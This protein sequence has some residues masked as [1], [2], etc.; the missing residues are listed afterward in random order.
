MWSSQVRLKMASSDD[1]PTDVIT[2][3]SEIEITAFADKPP[4]SLLDKPVEEQLKWQT[5][6]I[7]GKLGL[8]NT[9]E[10]REWIKEVSSEVF[11]LPLTRMFRSFSNGTTIEQLI[12]D[13]LKKKVRITRE[14]D[15]TLAK[16][17]FYVNFQL[18]RNN[19]PAL[20]V[21]SPEG[22]L[23]LMEFYKNGRL[24]AEGQPAQ[25]LFRANDGSKI[26]ES[27][28]RHGVVSNPNGPAMVMFD[29]NNSISVQMWYEN[30]LPVRT[31]RFRN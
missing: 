14:P 29:E 21:W 1:L 28:R 20:M 10:Y 7:I 23:T 13:G 19:A 22:I 6:N 17:E 25:I 30:G 11:D 15:G 16:L 9:P 2:L 18:S 3:V 27:W 5:E 24:H 8:P 12:S 4:P 31:E 26:R